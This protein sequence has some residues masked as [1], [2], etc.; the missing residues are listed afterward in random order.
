MLRPTIISI[1]SIAFFF[2]SFAQQPL[3]SVDIDYSNPKEYQIAGIRIV[4]VQFLDSRMLLLLSGLSEGDRIQVPGEAIN[5][6]IKNLWAQGLF[7]DV[8]VQ[9]TRTMGDK[10]WLDIVLKERPRLSYYN[11]EGISRSEANNLREKLNIT[12]GDM[13]NENLLITSQNKIKNHF[14]K[15][16]YY[17]VSTE[18]VQ[19]K[20]TTQNSGIALT[21]VIRKKRKV[22]VNSITFKGNEAL[23]D[24]KLK[25]AMKEVKEKNLFHVF[26][27]SKFNDGDYEADKKL[28]I[29]KYLES[30]LRDA[31]IV[32]DTMYAH[33]EKTVNIEIEINEGNKY[34]FRHITWLGNTKY[35][36]KQL[37]DI[38]NIQRGDVYNEAKLE[39]QLYMNPTGKDLSSLY[40]DNGYLFFQVNPVEKLV[41]NDSIDIELQI[42]EGKQARIS[43]VLVS[44]NTKTNDQVILREIRTKPG[45]LFSRSDIIRSQRELSQLGYFD[46]EAFD[47]VTTPH[48]ESS[49]VDIEY[50]VA[51]RPSDQVELSG[52]WGGGI[53]VGTLGLV[54]SNFSAKNMFKKGAWRPLPAGDGQRLSLRATS[55]GPSFQS[56]NMSFTEPWLGGKKP[57]SLNVSVFHTVRS[58]GYSKEDPNR[59]TLKLT[60][61]SAGIGWRLKWPDDFFSFY[62]QGSYQVYSLKNFTSG[63]FI[64]TDG[65]SNNLSGT[66]TLSRNDIDAPI[67]P[68]KGS[69]FSFSSQLTLPYSRWFSDKDYSTLPD[70]EKYKWIE[71]HKWKVHAAWYAPLDHYPKTKFV[72]ATRVGFGFLGYYNPGIGTSPFERF[73]MGGDGLSGFNLDGRELISMR[74]YGNNVLSPANGASYAAKYTMELRFA[75][76]TNPSAT[77]YTHLFAEA[78]NSWS[79]KEQFDPFRL[80][81]SVGVGLRLFLPMFG[82]LGVDYGIPMDKVEGRP[83]YE[84]RFQFTIGQFFNSWNSD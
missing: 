26:K 15:K 53:V 75:L 30:G 81:R 3:H 6:A 31:R 11:F 63:D 16:G 46:P 13:V 39:K 48:P 12:S 24:Q 33:D 65:R 64:F 35:T 5:K 84:E 49:T 73:Y 44:G 59:E 37:N 56:Y 68:K 27:V 41:E 38:L 47:V 61:G 80:K 43:K 52:G 72:L 54:F 83:V 18:V 74:G 32:S 23:S 17:F 70:A 82:L 21:F 7:E 76:S 78:G 34:Y 28:I 8:K 25:K 58:Y 67:F 10:I 51:E 19:Q 45:E 20:D 1:L 42:Y 2:Q 4:G 57:N 36:T 79:T 69:K 14:I 50:V 22:K 55:N 9:A 62:A 66:F 71:F 29:D 60:G 77:I 40:L